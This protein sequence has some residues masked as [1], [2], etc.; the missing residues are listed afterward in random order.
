MLDGGMHTEE[1]A[2]QHQTELAIASTSSLRR[3]K[4]PEEK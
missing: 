1:H 4:V 3:N 2:W